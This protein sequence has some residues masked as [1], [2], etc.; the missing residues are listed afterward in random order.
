MPCLG[1]LKWA[2]NE[3]NL[4][5]VQLKPEYL[6]DD[7][8]P[9][10][11]HE[12]LLGDIHSRFENR[13]GYSP[14]AFQDPLFKYSAESKPTFQLGRKIY[15]LSR[16]RNIS[17]ILISGTEKNPPKLVKKPTLPPNIWG[18]WISTKCEVCYLFGFKSIS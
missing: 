4:I 17:T 3:L 1:S 8:N 16:C 13:D 5:R 10:Y 6:S 7:Q 15:F 2:F 18:D 12:L 14:S 9:L 11:R